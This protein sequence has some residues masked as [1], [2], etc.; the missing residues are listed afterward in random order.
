MQRWR[1]REG[2]PGR[3]QGGRSAAAGAD[4]T[5][6]TGP[7]RFAPTPHATRGGRGTAN[8]RDAFQVT[9][10]RGVRGC[11]GCRGD[12]SPL[13]PC[14]A[15]GR[16]PAAH[17]GQQPQCREEQNQRQSKKSPPH[18]MPRAGQ[19]TCR[20]CR[21]AAARQGKRH[22]PQ[23]RQECPPTCAG[24]SSAETALRK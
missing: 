11:R 2:D 17:V 19:A 3:P 5:R 8:S 1:G 12:F 14:P 6:P 20:P 10:Q 7:G 16:R 23:K 9:A 13:T 24:K 18:P 4:I 21:A 22:Q 15:P